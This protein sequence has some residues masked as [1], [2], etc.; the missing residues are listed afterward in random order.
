MQTVRHIF[1]VSTIL[2]SLIHEIKTTLRFYLIVIRMAK[3]KETDAGY[4]GR[5]RDP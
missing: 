5:N 4:D 3:I 1:K 2:R